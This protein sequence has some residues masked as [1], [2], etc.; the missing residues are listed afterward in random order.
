MCSSDLILS[1][2]W[3]GRKGP[4]SGL[5]AGGQEL[6]RVWARLRAQGMGEDGLGEGVGILR[7]FED[8]FLGVAV[9]SVWGRD[10]LR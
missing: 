1:S 7:L 9:V 8:E 10:V 4:C 3:R 5:L 6:S 2:G